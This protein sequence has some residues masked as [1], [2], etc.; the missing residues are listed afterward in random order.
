MGIGSAR[1]GSEREIQV[2]TVKDG[3]GRE[4][5]DARFVE[6]FKSARQRMKSAASIGKFQIFSDLIVRVV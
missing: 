4:L 1:V 5:K 6:I 3:N 2:L